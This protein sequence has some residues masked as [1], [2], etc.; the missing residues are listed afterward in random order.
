MSTPLQKKWAAK[1][2]DADDVYNYDD[3]SITFVYAPKNDKLYTSKYPDTHIEVGYQLSPEEQAALKDI[4]RKAMLNKGYILGRMGHLPWSKVEGR[5]SNQ[6]DAFVI[7]VIAFWNQINFTEAQIKRTL[8]K[9]ME[10][11]PGYFIVP[12]NEVVVTGERGNGVKTSFLSDWGME[13]SGEPQSKKRDAPDCKALEKIDILG[14]PYGLQGI[15]GAIHSTKGEEL[16]YLRGSFCSA[17]PIK[18][19]QA[20][21]KDCPLQAKMLDALSSKFKCG[22]NDWNKY[23]NAGKFARRQQL[24]NIFSKPEEIDKNFRTQKE[25]DA[26]WD[27][28]MNK[29]ECVLNFKS[30]LT[31]KN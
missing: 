4:S 7:P 18:R 27:E 16:G 13:I 14:K 1:S 10:A 26:A 24:K 22:E 8:Q 17:Y 23:V 5:A 6:E 31:S 3:D 29:K 15:L 11:Y 30:W 28:L 25:I 20:Q 21:E 2:I 9:L 12:A 19:Q